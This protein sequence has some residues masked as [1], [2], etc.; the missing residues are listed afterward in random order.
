MGWAHRTGLTAR[1]K[2]ENLDNILEA[3]E[4]EDLKQERLSGEGEDGDA[5]AVCFDPKYKECGME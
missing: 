5:R 1:D 4:I 2:R 3:S